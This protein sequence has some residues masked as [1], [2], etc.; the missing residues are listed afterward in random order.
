MLAP[1]VTQVTLK[2]YIMSSSL[3]SWLAPI[4]C[5]DLLV[6]LDGYGVESVED[7]KMLEAEHISELCRKLKMIP[8]KKFREKMAAL[9][10]G[11]LSVAEPQPPS[12]ST[13]G[14]AQGTRIAGGLAMSLAPMNSLASRFRPLLK[15]PRPKFLDA[16]QSIE[17]AGRPSSLIIGHRPLAIGH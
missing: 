7:L 13:Q 5:N 16:I 14:H 3:E 1:T 12:G 6:P 4:K 9:Q 17:N 2:Q 10:Q 11:E 8:A 15:K